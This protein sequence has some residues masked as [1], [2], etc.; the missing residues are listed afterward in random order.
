MKI[1][2]DENILRKTCKELTKGDSLNYVNDMFKLMVDSKGVGIAA[3]QIGINKR[4]FLV[5]LDNE[6]V[7]LFINPVIVNKSEEVEEDTE[8]CLS[9]PDYF[10]KVI[11][12][13]SITIKYFNGKEHKTE[14]YIDFNARVI[15]HE[16]DHLDG[17]LYIDKASEV[18]QNDVTV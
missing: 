6:R 17:I 3:P 8:G 15:Q 5:V 4:L 9:V 12:H 1:V 14:T 11:R 2:T 16:Y 18:K 7:E 13:K 10:G